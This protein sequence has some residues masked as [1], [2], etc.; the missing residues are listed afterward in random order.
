MTVA[1]GAPAETADRPPGASEPPARAADDGG[2]RDI[3]DVGVV[4][5]AVA[6]VAAVVTATI[7][8]IVDDWYPV[9]DN[10]YFALRSADVLTGNHPLLGTW[11][12]ASHAV[13]FDVN[14]PGPLLF[15]A[16]AAPAKI[17][18]S[19]LPVGVAG[20][21]LGSVAIMALC[22]SRVAGRRG[23]LVALFASAA[24]AWAMGPELLVD[25][26]QPHSLLFPFLALVGATW[27]T[28]AGSDGSLAAV[29][30]FGSF[31]VQSHLS[32]VPIVAVL[33]GTA[34]V[35]VVARSVRDPERRSR[36]V[37]MLGAAGI[38]GLVLWSQP[39][40]EQFTA[41]DR[42]NLERIVDASGA[43]RDESVGP[44]LGVEIAGTLLS[45]LPAWVPTSFEDDFLPVPELAPV[46]PEFVAGPSR[47]V[48][49]VSL[50]AALAVLTAVG[51][52]AHRR[53]APTVAAGA[54]VV[55]LLV[56]I[57]TATV[58]TLPLKDYGLPPHHVRWLWPASIA[59]T[60]VLVSG[61]VA[62]RAG[63]VAVAGAT[64]VMSALA[65][66]P[67][68]PDVGPTA[69]EYAAPVVRELAPQLDALR[70]RGPLLFDPDGLR[71]FGP[72]NTPVI[73]ELEERGI[74]VV[75]DDPE[76]IRQLGPA[77]ETDGSHAGRFYVWEGGLAAE[78]RPGLERVAFVEGLDEVE[79]AELDDLGSRVGR[80]FADGEIR[81]TDTG[82]VAVEQ[83]R[84][85]PVDEIP[86][87]GAA[88]VPVG[89]GTVVAGVM[90]GFLSAP[91]QAVLDR[92]A[93]LQ[94]RQDQETVGVWVDW[95]DR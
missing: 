39:I 76:Y 87:D 3:V 64:V 9:G 65:F 17:D 1:A 82:Q 74:D 42:G 36:G 80:W 88:L 27:A 22:A 60:T 19:L 38:L 57:S 94:L 7:R 72:Y 23:V 45:P 55:G 75:V 14:N 33:G 62:R 85:P 2:A 41:D 84:M 61:L 13:G 29:V 18:P 52:F 40:V 31:L 48:A 50:V 11:T 8:A 93:A 4:A 90:Q 37:R 43:E 71:I 6:L 10:A 16:L 66:V 25:P 59:I 56:V 32:Y 91:D 81:L 44:A 46:P 35:A 15:D 92:W 47:T 30:G 73:L 95:A 54:A 34:V 69:D 49:A 77:R 26:W 86:V 28:W 70:G 78:G 53:R 83:G 79:R 51:V 24:L 20:L 58:A 89:R 67:T 63:V 5:S 68:H 12:S 21:V